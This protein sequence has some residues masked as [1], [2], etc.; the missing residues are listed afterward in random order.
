MEDLFWLGRSNEAQSNGE[1]ETCEDKYFE[2]ANGE[3]LRAK[4][5]MTVYQGREHEEFPAFDQ[6]VE[7]PA[8]VVST[9][10]KTIWRKRF[11]FPSGRG[12]MGFHNLERSE[13]ESDRDRIGSE[14]A[15]MPQRG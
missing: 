9:P 5:H 8:K 12:S 7:H 13:C 2:M 11:A 10:A 4:C 14:G 6:R 15:W 1:N 3:R